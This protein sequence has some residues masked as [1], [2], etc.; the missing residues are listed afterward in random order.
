MTVLGICAEWLITFIETAMC[1]LFFHLF[2]ENRFPKKKQRILFLFIA[3]VTTTGVIL[4]NLVEL[5]FSVAT[6]LYAVVIFALGGRVMYKGSLVD[7]LVVSLSFVTGLNVLEWGYLNLVIAR[8]WS[9]DV[10]EKMG[11]GFSPQRIFIITLAK[12]IEIAVCLLIAPLLKRLVH[13]LEKEKRSGEKPVRLALIPAAAAAFL[14]SLYLFSLFGT[15]FEPDINPAQ[16]ILMI[17]IVFLLC[18]AYL[19]Y[20][21]KLIQKEQI[22][23]ARQNGLLQKNYE[24]ARTAYQANAELY[25]DMRNLFLLLQNYLADGKVEE[26]QSYLE[27]LSGGKAIQNAACWTGLEAIDYILGQKAGEAE[28]RQIAATI[29]AESIRDCGI[30]PVDLCTILMNLLD[31]AIEGAEKCPAYMGKRM[32][33]TIRHIHQ[34]ILINVKNSAAAPPVQQNGSL[35]TTKKEK[36]LHG[37]GMKSVQSAAEKYDGT[38]EYVY[39]DSV[40]SVSVMLFIH[41]V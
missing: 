13:R 6:V 18:F 4:L 22:F 10:I 32:D 28:R 33:I 12:V 41:K 39:A 35:V 26:A 20:R 5:S 38:V 34:F 11:T 23:T 21:L 7:F 17:A 19:C 15:G 30:E 27:Q 25:H 37:W 1:H 2:F 29:H 40:F 8:I 24:M 16:M 14:S 3:A 31:N 36:W 9:P